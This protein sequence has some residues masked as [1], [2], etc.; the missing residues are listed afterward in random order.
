MV[1]ML[2]R[3][4]IPGFKLL[5]VF[6]LATKYKFCSVPVQFSLKPHT[7]LG[8]EN[9]HFCLGQDSHTPHMCSNR[10]E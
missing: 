4:D 2:F 10:V 1:Y 7:Q 5:G 3:E 8:Q 6:F 9:I